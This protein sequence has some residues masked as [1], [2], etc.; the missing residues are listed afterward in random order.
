[1]ALPEI[2]TARLRLRM[3]RPDD[4]EE[5]YA[6]L[7]NSE[8]TRYYPDIF[9]PPSKERVAA[10][11]VRHIERWKEHG[12]GEWALTHKESGKLLGYAGI[13]FVQRGPETE[14]FYGLLPE[15]WRQGF[16]LE[17]ARACLRYGFEQRKL[18]RIV[19][20]ANP[21]NAASVSIL[22]KLGMKH[23]EEASYYGPPEVCFTLSRED[24]KADDAV[25]HLQ[26]IEL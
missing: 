2:E 18:E 19:A 20:C 13:Q 10:G 6:M 9:S 4:L 22:E 7:N 17:A 3:Y 1:M 24:Y 21:A 5:R 23:D 11:L 12:F 26:F 8:V 25:Y 16:A 15:H 14:L